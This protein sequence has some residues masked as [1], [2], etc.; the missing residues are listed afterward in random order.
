MRRKSKILLVILCVFTILLLM[1]GV[2]LFWLSEKQKQ[3]EEEE[4]RKALEDQEE[5]KVEEEK[6]VEVLGFVETIKAQ[7]SESSSFYLLNTKEKSVFEVSLPADFNREVKPAFHDTKLY[8]LTSE[9]VL[10]DEESLTTILYSH[11]LKSGRREK[12]ATTSVNS[13]PWKFWLSGNGEKIVVERIEKNMVGEDEPVLE[14]SGKPLK[15][16]GFE[17]INLKDNS[18]DK[19]MSLEINVNT[20]ILAGYSESQNDFYY[21]KKENEEYEVVA[22]NL[23]DGEKKKPFALINY[24]SIDFDGFVKSD[25]SHLLSLSPNSKYLL[26]TD[27]EN[28]GQKT[29]LYQISTR[30]GAKEKILSKKGL[31]KQISWAKIEDKFAYLFLEESTGIPEIWT[32]DPD[33][34]NESKVIKATDRGKNLSDLTYSSDD[35][36]LF[37]AERISARSVKV[38][39]LEND[40]YTEDD[41]Y[42]REILPNEDN[43]FLEIIA[44]E[45]TEKDFPWRAPGMRQTLSDSSENTLD[46]SEITRENV[47]TYLSSNLAEAIR[48][49]PYLGED[50]RLMSLGFPKNEEGRVYV[51]F[52]DNHEMGQSLLECLKTDGQVYCGLVGTFEIDGLD[53]RLEIGEDPLAGQVIQHYEKDSQ[54][55]NYVLSYETG[56]KEV[57]PV[58]LDTARESQKK[59]DAGEER[60]RTLAIEVAKNDLPERFNLKEAEYKVIS[61]D[62]KE[63]TVTLEAKKDSEV[64]H[65]NL[66]KLV[67]K[68]ATGIWTL[69]SIKNVK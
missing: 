24:G 40:K 44:S 1:F 58:S 31:I 29:D 17:V 28:D 43:I 37:F 18:S 6:G 45:R 61:E 16:V 36:K 26:Y 64:Y 7:K 38:M 63:G 10:E 35:S 50:W 20:N 27:S 3:Q 62:D 21:I 33:G 12:I 41:I 47:I 59:V 67:R 32:S 53:W 39:A 48:K 15:K 68:D 66:E 55:G 13:Y 69:V 42:N 9:N 30:N 4:N 8:Y 5:A 54:S 23:E 34:K 14:S 57:F 22:V 49:D 25:A 51:V 56:E 11:D 52:S 60:F 46:E 2:G 19:I 65:I